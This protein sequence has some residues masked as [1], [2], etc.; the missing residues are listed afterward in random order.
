MLEQS[1]AVC[2]RITHR[3]DETCLR[4]V[5]DEVPRQL[6]ICYGLRVNDQWMRARR[7]PTQRHA[8]HDVQELKERSTRFEKLS[9]SMAI[10]LEEG[11][12]RSIVIGCSDAM[13]MF[14]LEEKFAMIMPIY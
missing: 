10:N 11:V 1:A 4:K 5:F 2:N 9:R 12:D 7:T 8:V 6:I 14:M 13:F 3:V